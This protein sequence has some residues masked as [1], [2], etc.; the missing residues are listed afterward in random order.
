MRPI[1]ICLTPIRNESWILDMFLKATSL[2][3]DHI[4]LADQ[5]STDGSREI[6]KKNSKVILIDN[7]SETF[8]EPERQRLL[9][10]EARKIAGPLLLISLDADEIFSPEIF[11][12]QE[13]DKMLASKPGTIIE[14]RWANLFPGFKKYWKS[15]FF[16]FAYM[17]DGAKHDENSKIHT[18]RIPVPADASIIKMEE[19]MVMHFQYTDW[20]RMQS[21]HRWYQCYE[22][23]SYPEKSALDIFRIYHHMYSIN[24]DLIRPLPKIWLNEYKKMQIDITKSDSDRVFWWDEKVLSYFDEYGTTY[25]SKLNLWAFNWKAVAE[26]LNNK[27]KLHY[28]D[29]RKLSDRVVQLY[30]KLTQK[31]SEKRLI[32]RIDGKIKSLLQY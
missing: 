25:F 5:M 32:R 7:N 8:N 4:I 6:A 22:R 28:Q 29:P 31:K 12:S 21:K 27:N 17:D 15:E 13:W 9:I 23:I 16:P 24:K 30:L 18:A 26:K 14:F 1:V 19:I 3:A 20:K 2:W 10:N 11:Y